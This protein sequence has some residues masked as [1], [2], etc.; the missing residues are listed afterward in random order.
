MFGSRRGYK[1]A[2]SLVIRPLKTDKKE[3]K[4]IGSHG[5][6]QMHLPLDKIFLQELTGVRG[7]D[8]GDFFGCAAC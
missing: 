2:F 5:I 3:N 8:F 6:R 7:F 4:K 1:G